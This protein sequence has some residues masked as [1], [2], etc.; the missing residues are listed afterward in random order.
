MAH[1]SKKK[2]K[3]Q[4][5]ATINAPSGRKQA[6]VAAYTN[7]IDTA[8]HHNIPDPD[9]SLL[10]TSGSGAVNMQ[11]LQPANTI[12]TDIIVLCTATASLGAN[13]FVGLKAGLTEGGADIIPDVNNAILK[14]S[15]KDIPVGHG[16]SIHTK[17]ANSLSGSAITFALP[18]GT[19][20]AK[21]PVLATEDRTIFIQVS[22]SNGFATDT[23][24]FKPI[25][26]FERL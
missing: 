7:L 5:D 9:F 23:G 14:L 17:I 4:L 6:T 10:T 20:S 1:L 8:V 22:A 21:P 15:Q 19:L 12:L 18:D 3:A 26:H 13:G 25:M 24:A 16:T 11:V 2:L